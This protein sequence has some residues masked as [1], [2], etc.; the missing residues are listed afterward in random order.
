MATTDL[1]STEA[2]EVTFPVT[3]M[4][5]A[6]CVR[7][8]EKAL[9]RVEGVREAS[10]NLATEK[11]H[12]VYDPGVASPERMR[13]AVEKAGYGVREFPQADRAVPALA[14]QDPTGDVMLPIQGM[15]CA[16]CVRRVEKALGR[17][18]GVSEASVNLA[19]EQAHVVFDPSRASLDSMRAA[20]DKAKQLHL[21]VVPQCPFARRWLREHPDEHGV[22]IDWHLRPAGD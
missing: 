9:G 1:T 17:V 10:V 11:A 19:T 5:C 4:T 22:P 20:V 15:T 18:E 3:G 12:V 2:T 14:R 21:I 6:S 13:V 7:R 16:S 8:I